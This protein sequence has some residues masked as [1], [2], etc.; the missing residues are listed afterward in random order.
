MADPDVEEGEIKKKIHKVLILPKAKILRGTTEKGLING[1]KKVPL[2]IV[3]VTKAICENYWFP[4]DKCEIKT[5]SERGLRLHV[6]QIHHKVIAA[7]WSDFVWEDSPQENGKKKYRKQSAFRWPAEAVCPECGIN[8]KRGNTSNGGRRFE[9]HQ[10]QHKVF[11]FHC[12]CPEMISPVVCLVI[13]LN[14][15]ERHMK[16]RHMG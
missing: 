11:N 6:T 12:N 10:M 2:P 14:I 1:R 7:S 16:V 9:I 8:V 13:P 4:C 15:K 3:S 5:K